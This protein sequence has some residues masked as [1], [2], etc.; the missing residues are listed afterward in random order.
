MCSKLSY[1]SNHHLGQAIS[2]SYLQF[3]SISKLTS[4]C[5]ENQQSLFSSWKDQ[6]FKIP[7]TRNH[8][9]KYILQISNL[10]YSIKFLPQPW[11]SIQLI[12]ISYELSKLYSG[13]ID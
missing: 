11:T 13:Q 9:S 4:D 2:V 5:N 8:D 10:I 3:N 7:V 6:V 1:L 12:K